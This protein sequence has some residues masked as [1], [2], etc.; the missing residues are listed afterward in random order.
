MP[1]QID[2]H[3]LD[4]IVVNANQDSKIISQHAP[5]IQGGGMKSNRYK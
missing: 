2:S 3:L 4:T 5:P 1:D